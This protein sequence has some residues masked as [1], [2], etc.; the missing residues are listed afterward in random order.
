MDLSVTA[1]GVENE[2]TFRA[3]QG[4]GCDQAQGDFFCKPLPPDAFIEWLRE[5]RWKVA[6]GTEP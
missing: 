1:E 4:L 6:E 2:T 5:S 3:L